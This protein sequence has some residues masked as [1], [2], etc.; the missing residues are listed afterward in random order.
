MSIEEAATMSPTT[1][2]LV[3]VIVPVYNGARYLSEC[4]ESV[5]GQTWQDFEIIV[6]NDGSTD[7][8]VEICSRFPKVKIVCQ[9]N[10][11]Q[12][13]A[14]NR[15]VYEAKG[16]FIA[17]I[18]QD[19]KWY[20]EK[21]ARQVPILERGKYGMVYSNVDRIDEEGRIVERNFLDKVSLQP[22]QSIRDCLSQDMFILPG[23]VLMTKELFE[24]LGG[25]DEQLSGY[26]DDDLFLRVFQHTRIY[27]IPEALMQ[28]R[29]YPT[30]YSY[31]ER[32][33][34]SREI[35]LKKLLKMF[36]DY[37]DRN[38]Y[39]T[40]D[41]IVPRFI[42]TYLFLYVQSLQFPSA[43]GQPQRFRQQLLSLRLRER[44]VILWALVSLPVPVMRQFQKIWRKMPVPLQR[45]WQRFIRGLIFS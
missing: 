36:P 29:I 11:G 1:R 45:A 43:Q 25:F 41:L 17:F 9:E 2:P 35:Y 6:V 14:R 28:W 10:K 39:F 8:S 19:D 27:Y 24:K 12:S 23:T 20:P 21:L 42:K 26:E 37:P 18:D 31:T 22:K 13:A 30:S 15:G 44:S 16:K 40:R 32:M 7:E 4:L 38:E 3:S 34:R 33:E 5:L